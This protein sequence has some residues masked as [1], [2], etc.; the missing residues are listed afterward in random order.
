MTIHLPDDL[1]TLVKEAVDS[2]RFLSV[3]VAIAQAV[4]LL[5]REIK[6]GQS[7]AR[8]ANRE[9]TG[10]IGSIGAMRDAADELEEIVA[11]AM[12]RRGEETW[13]DLTIK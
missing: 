10:G 12:K 11:D 1:E 9:D 3:E 5:L 4:R 7:P 8:T 6:H 13:R 2:G